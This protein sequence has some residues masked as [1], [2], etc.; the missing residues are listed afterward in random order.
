[1]S[2]M[3]LSLARYCII[4]HLPCQVSHCQW[5]GTVLSLTSHVR[6]IIVNGK[7]LYYHSPPMSGMS[8]SMARYCIITHLPCQVSHCKWQGTLIYHSRMRWIILLYLEPFIV[9]NC[10]WES[11]LLKVHCSFHNS[12][13]HPSFICLSP[14]SATV[15]IVITD[16][17]DHPPQF[18]RSIYKTTMSESYRRGASITSVSAS[19]KDIGINAKLTYILKEQ[20]REYFSMTSVEAT[21]TGVLKVFRVSAHFVLVWSLRIT[22]MCMLPYIQWGAKINLKLNDIILECRSI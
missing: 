9:K 8:L 19:D 12:S 20:D 3:S 6:Y 7:V 5:L 15:T 14:A 4:T 13:Y 22:H 16:V 17:N 10:L 18:T 1:M 2:G 21:N 11:P